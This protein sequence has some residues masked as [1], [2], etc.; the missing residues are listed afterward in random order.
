MFYSLEGGLQIHIWCKRWVVLTN[1][2][3][4]AL[5]GQAWGC[6][7]TRTRESVGAFVKKKIDAKFAGGLLAS[8]EAQKDILNSVVPHQTAQRLFDSRMENSQTRVALARALIGLKFS[9][10]KS[11]S[12]VKH[13]S[14]TGNLRGSNPLLRRSSTWWR[15]CS[16]REGQ[17]QCCD[18]PKVSLLA[19][20][21]SCRP[22]SWCTSSNKK[23][24]WWSLR[25]RLSILHYL[26][27]RFGAH[28]PATNI[29]GIEATNSTQPPHATLLHSSVMC[30][31]STHQTTM[32]TNHYISSR[33]LMGSSS[34][35]FILVSGFKPCLSCGL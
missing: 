20:L 6:K 11:S 29:V 10:S 27:S 14:S 19:A 35:N 28:L 32:T 1:R 33:G 3:N 12:C 25:Q 34:L 13:E 23:Q 30:V 8:K 22:H 16:S 15:Y 7:A 26:T 2:V 5:E 18:C 4:L 17:R 24:L 9:R 31:R 21:C